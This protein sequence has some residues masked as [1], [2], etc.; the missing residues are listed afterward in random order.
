MFLKF[1]DVLF[2]TSFNVSLETF[3]KRR[4]FCCLIF[5]CMCAYEYV[6]KC[7]QLSGKT[8]EGI[9]YHDWRVSA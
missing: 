5:I 1:S 6:Y 7:T 9:G 2:S 8:R 3:G 4:V